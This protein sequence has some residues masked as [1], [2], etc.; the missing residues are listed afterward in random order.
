MFP[1]V[2]GKIYIYIYIY[3]QVKI[4]KT[5]IG[6]FTGA[7]KLWRIFENVITMKILERIQEKV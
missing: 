1:K 7:G 3:I 6:I 4:P 5:V 2:C